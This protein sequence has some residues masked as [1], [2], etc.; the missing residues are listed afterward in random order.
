M[1]GLYDYGLMLADPRARLYAEALRRTVRPG[2]VVVEIGSGPGVLAIYA[3]TL[4]ARR[5][6]A[7]ES[8][9]IVSLAPQIAA[10]NGVSDRVVVIRG[11]SRH[12]TLD[13]PADVVVADVRG[14]LPFAGDSLDTMIDAR[15]FLKPGGAL[16]PH[17]DQVWVSGV[18]AP[19]LY[20]SIVDPWS[21]DRFG[22]SAAAARAIAVN[23]WRKARFDRADL[24]AAPD[25]C[26]DLDYTALETPSAEG[27]TRL[28]AE[29]ACDAH[30]LAAWFD[31]ELA[32]GVTMLNGPGEP[33]LLYGQGFFPWPEVVHL[34][35][36]DEVSVTF[37]ALKTVN[38]Y[39]FAWDTEIV[40]GTTRSRRASFAQSTFRGLP[41][42]LDTAY[43]H[44]PDAVV[45][46][47]PDA[48]IEQFVLSAFDGVRSQ[49]DIAVA[50]S[51]RFPDRFASTRDALAR[52]VAIA[53]RVAR[54]PGQVVL[55]E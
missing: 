11:D 7:I 6:Y 15:R 48:D 21:A 28:I 46:P 49:L 36:G 27:R 14:V 55:R 4:G 9:E 42:D 52:V 20:A 31:S 30:G 34:Q 22:V 29:R 39:V 47:G 1:Y 8:D 40:D 10:A 26:I 2:S 35:P 13:E 51:A 37:R 44:A 38:E 45:T 12:V 17:R 23:L 53:L 32:A 3:C 19:T 33:P 24:I 54:T 43:L 18:Y 16:I 5:V 25:V 41:L 50:L